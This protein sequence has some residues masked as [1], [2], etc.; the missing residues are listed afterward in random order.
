VAGSK[1]STTRLKFDDLLTIGKRAELRA[2]ISGYSATLSLPQV[3]R[4]VSHAESLEPAVHSLRLGIIHTYTSELLDP[5]LALAAALQGLKLQTYH[6]PYGLSLH[7]AQAN[8]GLVTHEPDLTLLLLRRED[9][10]PDLSKPLVEFSSARQNDLGNETLEQ[11]CGIVSQFRVHKVGQILLTLL[12]PILSPGLG[13]YDAQ[14]ERSESAWWANLKANIGRCLRESMQ[15]SLFFDL[16]EVLQ[17]IGR[18]HF[19]D[20]RFWYSARF[21]FTAEAAGEIARRVVGLGAVIKFPK[22]KVI[23]LDADNTLW[24][25]IIGED[26][27]NGIALGPD[28]PGNAFVDF[29]RRLLDYRQRGLVLALCSKNNPADLEQVFKEHPHQILRDEHFAAR[30]VNWLPKPDNLVSLA[31]ELN[32]GLDSFLVVDDSDYECATVRHTFPEVEVVQTPAKPVDVPTCLDHV[33]RLEVL[34]LTVED[35]AKTEL[36]AQERRRRESQRSLGES[37]I[38]LRDYLAS[39]ET[40]IRVGFNDS[41]HLARLSQLAQKTNQFNLTTR[42]YNEQQMQQFIHDGDWLVAHFS[43]ADVFGD[44]GIVGLAILHTITSQ[45]AELDTF[46]ISCRVLGREAESA[47]LHALLR[48]LAD[49]GVNEVVA[50]Y[51]PTPKNAPAKNFLPLQGFE[52]CAEGRYRRDLCKDPPQPESAFPVTVEL[53]VELAV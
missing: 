8:S 9:L 3:Q 5:W 40:K 14:S 6:A 52:K 45:Q 33:A 15:A 11:L 7:E 46:L 23:V 10:H 16:D 29:Q 42:R 24:G 25:G 35:L 39:L 51:S 41:A 20:H 53:A 30:R 4:L 47:F 49:Q 44:S 48:R 18:L 21:P 38:A 13:I 12:P 22:A 17:Q 27:I 43:L 19:F 2:A 32:V 28:Y 34:S 1:V 36:Y 37:G 50:Y 31:E 26:G